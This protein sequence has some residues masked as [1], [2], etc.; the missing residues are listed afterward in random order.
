[1]VLDSSALLAILLGEPGHEALRERLI[2]SESVMI[3]A[4]TVVETA[5]VLAS[6]LRADPIAPLDRVLRELGVVVVPFSESH[7]E[8][9]VMAYLAFGKGRHSAGLNLGDCLSYAVAKNSGE[10]LLFVGN[11]FPQTD[12]QP[13]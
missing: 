12:I 3:G 4:P 5:M 7:A 6:R 1:M 2:A 11:D 10:P 9:A 8:T 13:G